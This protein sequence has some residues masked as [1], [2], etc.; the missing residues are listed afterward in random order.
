VNL[1]IKLEA[2]DTTKN[3]RVA[4][5]YNAGGVLFTVTPDSAH[6]DRLSS[7]IITGTGVDT[8]GLYGT[9]KAILN[10]A[11]WVLGS[12]TVNV[13]SNWAMGPF[14]VAVEDTAGGG[15]KK[16]SKSTFVI[17]ETLF[18]K[19]GVWAQ[20]EGVN[21][22]SVQGEFG[23][24]VVPT[25]QYGN[26]ST[27]NIAFLDTRQGANKVL[28]EVFVEIASN[29]AQVAVPS[30]P[31]AVAKGG[32]DFIGIA[33]DPL[34]TGLIISAITS[35]AVGDT[36]QIGD[37]QKSANGRTAA[38]SFAGEGTAPPPET[39][40]AP[41]TLIVQDYLGADGSGD[42]GGLLLVSFPNTAQHSALSRYRLF[43]QISVTVDLV[44]GHLVTVDPAVQK[45]ISWTTIDAVPGGGDGVT[46]AVVPT[47]TTRRAPG[48]LPRNVGHPPPR[49]RQP[50]A[51][52]PSRACS[53]W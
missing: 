2:I 47:L 16:G 14:T 46:R 6:A 50:S 10:S 29:K 32:S 41:D 43:R 30:G 5:T 12:R 33:N 27:K 18:S 9:G 26:P 23:I 11:G 4:V 48:P 28:N 38:L 21:T 31:Q 1:P 53:R 24:R 45:W 17:D 3:N 36:S 40:D 8:V 15:S 44:D 20:E 39:L 37:A 25:D 42:Q 35:S 34:G 7:V 22:T 52:S 13:K 19:Y 49:R 51:C